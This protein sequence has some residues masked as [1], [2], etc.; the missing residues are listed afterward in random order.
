MRATKKIRIAHVA[1]ASASS[2]LVELLSKRELEVLYL[3][4]DGCTNREIAS[5]F[6]L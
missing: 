1:T 4:A 6:F 3:I 5:R 2:E